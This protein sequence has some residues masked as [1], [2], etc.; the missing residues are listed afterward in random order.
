[1]EIN[2]TPRSWMHHRS[3]TQPQMRR[4][5]LALLIR[6]AP[7]ADAPSLVT[8]PRMR[9]HPPLI[10]EGSRQEWASEHLWIEAAAGV[11]EE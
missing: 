10:G 8:Q 11:V 3:L 7:L 6:L 5:P 9:R 2:L 4:H 1:M